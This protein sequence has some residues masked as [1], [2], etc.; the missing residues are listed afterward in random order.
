MAAASGPALVEGGV[1]AGVGDRSCVGTL[2][3]L[4]MRAISYIPSGRLA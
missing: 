4:R 3:G 2:T 1:G